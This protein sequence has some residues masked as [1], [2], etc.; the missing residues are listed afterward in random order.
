[1]RAPLG[2]YLGVGRDDLVFVPSATHGVNIVARS[3]HTS[4]QRRADL[5][6]L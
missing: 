2:G 4:Q 3:V 5:S 1:M 6:V